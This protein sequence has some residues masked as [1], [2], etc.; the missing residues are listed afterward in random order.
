MTQKEFN[1]EFREILKMNR[2]PKGSVEAYVRAMKIIAL[3]L[4][5]GSRFKTLYARFLKS[6]DLPKSS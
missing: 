5:T 6:N 3:Q 2:G 4:S 1:K